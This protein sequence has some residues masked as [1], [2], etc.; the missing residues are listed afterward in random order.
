MKFSEKLKNRLEDKSGRTYARPS[1]FFEKKMGTLFLLPT[2]VVLLGVGIFPLLYSLWVS[3]HTYYLSRPQ[4]GHDFIGLKNYF[5]TFQDPAFWQALSITIRFAAMTLPIQVFLGI[6]IA[7]LLNREQRIVSIYRVPLIVP[8]MVTPV[9]VGLIWRLIYNP[10]FG[11]LNYMLGKLGFN[12]VEWLGSPKVSLFAIALVD[13][14]QWTPLIMLVCL[15]NLTA[16]PKENIEAAVVDGATS[17][18]IFKGITFPFILPGILTVLILRTA[19]VI[20]TFDMVFVLTRGGPGAATE[21][22]SLYVYRIGLMVFDLGHAG[23]MA[24]M[25]LVGTMLIA[26]LYLRLFYRSVDFVL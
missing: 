5:D 19:D 6:A 11:I 9:V 18:Q 7:L 3:F 13:I 17:W 15:A 23:A 14:W 1:S 4:M 25:L 12:P 24:F 20:R 16:I 21:L 8:M 22:V 2:I 26:R 10:Q